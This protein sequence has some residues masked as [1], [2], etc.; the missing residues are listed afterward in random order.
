[1][2]ILRQKQYATGVERAMVAMNKIPKPPKP[3]IKEIAEEKSRQKRED[4]I[5]KIEQTLG[6]EG[7][8]KSSLGGFFRG[9]STRARINMGYNTPEAVEH[10]RKKKISEVLKDKSITPEAIE[11]SLRETVG[12]KVKKA[13]GNIV[14]KTKKGAKA[15]YVDTS[16]VA[17]KGMGFAVGHPGYVISQGALTFG[18]MP[19]LDAAQYG[20][21]T[22]ATTATHPGTAAWGVGKWITDD[23]PVK[24][25][26]RN[27]E[28][29][30]VRD[31]SGKVIRRKIPLGKVVK[32]WG[33]I[34]DKNIVD[35]FEGKGLKGST[36]RILNTV[37]DSHKAS[38][39]YDNR[40]ITR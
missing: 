9:K 29:K 20:A 18:P 21:Y 8:E 24:K 31:A 37:K 39:P 32:R 2:I 14:E 36:K 19:F 26:I 33:R 40:I 7:L 1:M 27:A 15:F 5:K 17:G 10:L 35:M 30:R 34:A 23:I 4:A 6:K 25:A 22:A 16:K 28:G 38:H 12:Q 3:T 13:G 11:E